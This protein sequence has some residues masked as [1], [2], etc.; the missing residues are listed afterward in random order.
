MQR[1]N[2]QTISIDAPRET[3]LDLI[4]DPTAFPR[5]ASGFARAVRV[6]GADWLVATG[7][8][9]IRLHVRVSREHGTVDFLAAAALPGAE[10]GV[11]TRV[12]PNGRG[13]DLVL[14]RFFPDAMTDTDLDDERA[15]VAVELQTVRVLSERGQV[16]AAAA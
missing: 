9:E 11:F 12:V 15:V 8:G 3:V 16:R 7:K 5:W 13:C 10:R 4:S 6:D 1:S 2:T 14:T